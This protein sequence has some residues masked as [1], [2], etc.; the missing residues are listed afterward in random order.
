MLWCDEK[1]WCLTN[2][3]TVWIFR[4]R[5]HHQDPKYQFRPKRVP[6][7]IHTWACIGHSSPG[8]FCFFDPPL[9]PEMYVEILSKH[10][11]PT[12]RRLCGRKWIFQDDGSGSHTLPKMEKKPQSPHAAVAGQFA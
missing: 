4:P 5:G 10:A 3:G 8:A 7:S 1:E 9:R 6:G 12:A 2:R 11:L